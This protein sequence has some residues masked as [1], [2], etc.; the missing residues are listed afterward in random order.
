MNAPGGISFTGDWGRYRAIM[1]GIGPA[2]RSGGVKY[3]TQLALKAEAIAVGHLQKQDLGWAPLNPRYRAKKIA[4]GR[5]EKTLIATSQMFQAITAWSDP[6]TLTAYAGI[7]RT[8]LYKK[9][10]NAVM[11]DKRGRFRKGSGRINPGGQKVWNIA[12]AH[13]FGHGVPER[14]LWRP[15]MKDLVKFAKNTDLL[16][17]LI[18]AELSRL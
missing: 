13:E 7:R 6:A 2:V 4:Q 18:L 1:A 14:P 5:S 8:V 3:Q 10:R 15:T 11:R 12:R 9:V 17:R 16:T